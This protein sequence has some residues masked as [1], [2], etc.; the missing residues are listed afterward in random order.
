[1]DVESARSSMELTLERMLSKCQCANV[2]QVGQVRRAMNPS[3]RPS[4]RLKASA[5]GT[6]HVC[7]MPPWNRHA[8]AM[9]IG[10]GRTVELP[11]VSMIAMAMDNAKKARATAVPSGQVSTASFPD[12]HMAVSTVFAWRTVPASAYQ[13]TPEMRVTLNA[14]VAAL[15]MV[16]VAVKMAFPLKGANARLDMVEWIVQRSSALLPTAMSVTTMVNV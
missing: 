8:F 4:G 10:E 5:Q 15:A 3:A 13:A 6:V 14:L 11:H 9:A 12:A 7:T 1:M 16:H 2:S